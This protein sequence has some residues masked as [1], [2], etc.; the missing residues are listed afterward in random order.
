VVSVLQAIYQVER[1]ELPLF[2]GQQLDVFV[3]AG[4]Q[5]WVER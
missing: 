2:V 1:E 5:D 3:D 4:R